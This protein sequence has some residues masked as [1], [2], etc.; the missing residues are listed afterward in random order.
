MRGGTTAARLLRGVAL[1]ERADEERSC[2]APGAFTVVLLVAR[3][4]ERDD[5]I[6]RGEA[7][8]AASSR[9][10]FFTS[11]WQSTVPSWLSSKPFVSVSESSSETSILSKCF[12]MR[13]ISV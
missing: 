11:S 1:H 3:K 12:I 6:A 2:E 4:A 13:L 9:F 7:F 5:D 8:A 10:T